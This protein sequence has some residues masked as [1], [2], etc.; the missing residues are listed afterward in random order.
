MT[1]AQDTQL[2]A[3]LLLNRV[4]EIEASDHASLGYEGLMRKVSKAR[5]NDTEEV[6]NTL[7]AALILAGAD[8]WNVD[9]AMR[10]VTNSAFSYVDGI[11][12]SYV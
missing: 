7:A 2:V 3:S 10:R 9:E 6:L 11:P 5:L 4:A 1:S 12:R 8:Q